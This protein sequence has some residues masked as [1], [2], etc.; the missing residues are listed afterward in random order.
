MDPINPNTSLG[1]C[2]AVFVCLTFCLILLFKPEVY[3][4][5]VS[6][7]SIGEVYVKFSRIIRKWATVISVL[8]LGLTFL[9]ST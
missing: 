7:K 2:R 3:C 8:E 1:S 4:V 5:L 6:Y 9:S